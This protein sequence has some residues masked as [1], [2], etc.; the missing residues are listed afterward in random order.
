MIKLNLHEVKVQFSKYIEMVEAG[1]TIVVCKRN[2]PVAEIRQVA[3]SEK[4]TP[5]LGS[6]AG[7][8]KIPKSFFKSMSKAELRLWEE[9]DKNDPLKKYAPRSA[10]RLK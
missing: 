8:G 10:K 9:G 7:K 6:A 1:E 4:R 3:A 2:I 5:V